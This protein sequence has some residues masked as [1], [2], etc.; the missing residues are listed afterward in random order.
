MLQEFSIIFVTVANYQI[1]YLELPGLG[2]HL[3]SNQY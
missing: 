2:L 1:I 3:E